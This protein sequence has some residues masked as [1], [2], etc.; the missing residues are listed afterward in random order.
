MCYIYSFLEDKRKTA[1]EYLYYFYK[2]QLESMS[3]LY[4]GHWK[5]RGRQNGKLKYINEQSKQCG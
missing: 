1:K 2:K 3:E 5:V 4:L